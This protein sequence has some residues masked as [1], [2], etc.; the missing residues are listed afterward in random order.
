MD[1]DLQLQVT[2][3]RVDFFYCTAYVDGVDSVFVRGALS[4]Q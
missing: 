1:A 4:N 3:V 2:E